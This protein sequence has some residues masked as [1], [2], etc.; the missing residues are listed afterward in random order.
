MK[1]LAERLGERLADRLER[2]GVWGA[3]LVIAGV[4][5][6]LFLGGLLSTLALVEGN[7]GGEYGLLM[8][9]VP[10]LLFPLMVAL[11]VVHMRRDVPLGLRMGLVLAPIPT[12]FAVLGV[13][14]AFWPACGPAEVFLS[15][16]VWGGGFALLGLPY[17]F[18]GVRTWLLRI[19]LGVAI[20]VAT[21]LLLLMAVMIGASAGNRHVDGI[22]SYFM[23]LGV[24]LFYQVGASYLVD[25]VVHQ[26]RRARADDPRVR[27]VQSLL[28]H[29]YASGAVGPEERLGW[30]ERLRALEASD[31][32]QADAARRASLLKAHG[33]AL[34][35]G[36]GIFL[37]FTL[38]GASAATAGC[39]P[40][41]TCTAYE[42]SQL[43]MVLSLPASYAT[44]L[45]ASLV[46]SGLLALALARRAAA[47]A[48]RD[49]VSFEQGAD[50]LKEEVLAAVRARALAAGKSP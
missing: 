41:G 20:L 5:P 25:G 50:A 35:I 13:G 29:H 39:M 27:D 16:L 30:L 45:S 7:L 43:K 15:A 28:D 21:S 40:R 11:G 23:L 19:L 2:A 48:T 26:A 22:T 17:L 12:T 9:A 31:R 38:L 32:R 10:P 47:E 46:L 4:T 1:H 18:P 49:G 14:C 33:W 44:G 3:V 6:A 34:A 37:A 24:L 36:G 8:L 42:L